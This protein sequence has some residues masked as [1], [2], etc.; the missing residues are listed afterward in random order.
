MR[1]FIIA[2]GHKMPGWIET[3]FAEY[4]KRMPPELR[5]ELKEIKPEQRSN[6]RTAETVMAAEAQRIEAALPRGCRLV[7]LDE[8]GQDLTTM[9]LAQSLTVWQQDGRD[10][11][12]VIGGADGLDPTLK[13][14]ADTLIRLSS[15]TLPHGMVRVLLAEQLYRAW[16][17]NANHPY[18]RV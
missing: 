3:A 18:H 2:V 12:F 15:L 8:R 16:S 14:R 17:I 13:S 5:I 9:R 7:C 4:A 10:V 6:S 1:L 11:A